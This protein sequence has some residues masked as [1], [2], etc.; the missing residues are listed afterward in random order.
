[1]D[2]L[3][4]CE[5]AA[6]FIMPF[7]LGILHRRG[8]ITQKQVSFTIATYFSLFSGTYYLSLGNP[9]TLVSIPLVDWSFAIVLSLFCWVFVYAFTRWLSS[10]WYQK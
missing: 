6:F 8:A 4:N 3:I 5:I 9:E 7:V 2:L 1:M 10:Q